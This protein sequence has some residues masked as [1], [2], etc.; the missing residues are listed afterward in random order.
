MLLTFLVSITGDLWQGW[1][2]ID[3]NFNDSMILPDARI[4]VKFCVLPRPA[5]A[6][7][8]GQVSA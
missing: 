8:E 3:F 6:E 1:C 2:L 4:L 7:V 5:A